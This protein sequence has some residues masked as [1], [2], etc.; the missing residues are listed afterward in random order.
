MILSHIV[1]ASE[2]NVIG[3]DNELPWSIPEDTRFFMTTTRGHA[4]IMGRKTFESLPG[5]LPHR[6]HVVITHDGSFAQSLGGKAKR[7]DSPVEVVS[8]IDQALELCR[9]QMG[10]WGNEV[11]IIGG[12]EIYKQTLSI[13][14]RVYLTRIYDE[15]DGDVFYPAIDENDFMEVKRDDHNGELPFSFLTYER[16]KT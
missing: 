15:F 16:R 11:F 2:N 6:L 4:L 14:D 3:R 5:I 10:K 8:N 1:A 13:V 7:E 9:T 12:G